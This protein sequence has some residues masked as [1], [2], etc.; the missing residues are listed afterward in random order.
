MKEDY[1][2]DL[3]KFPL[4]RFKKELSESELIPSRKILKEKINERFEI[5]EN[6]GIGNLQDLKVSLKTP[7]KTR[8]FAG[9]SGLPEDYLLILRRE[10]N[11]YT[12]NPVNLEKFPGV[13]KETVNKLKSVGIKNTAHLF[14]KVKTPEDRIKLAAELEIPEEEILELAK[15][16]DLSRI[17]WVGPVSARIFLDS[18]ID[19]VEKVSEADAGSFYKKLVELNQKKVYQS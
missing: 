11:S 14:K 16:T 3:E 7:K 17:K 18:G 4:N 2:I 15:L 1:H 19:T 5:L 12:P 6:N 8:E 13:E 9:K 10:V